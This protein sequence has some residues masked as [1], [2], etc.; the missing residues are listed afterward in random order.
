MKLFRRLEAEPN[1]L[2]QA[3]TAAAGH[4]AENPAA[5]ARPAADDQA[6]F[7]S[8]QR[9]RDREMHA[10]DLRR[11]AEHRQET[12]DGIR[13]ALS[14]QDREFARG[15][16]AQRETN[17]RILDANVRDSAPKKRWWQ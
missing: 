12:E 15:W 10:D 14:V 3:Y 6:M 13:D 4:T 1:P 5:E 16:A 11:A 17:Q 7:G 2:I 8:K 9:Q